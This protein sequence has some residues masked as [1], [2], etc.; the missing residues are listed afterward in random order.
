VLPQIFRWFPETALNNFPMLLT[1][2]SI[3]VVSFIVPLLNQGRSWG[4][5][6]L[7]ISTLFREEVE[8]GGLILSLSFRLGAIAVLTYAPGLVVLHTAKLLGFWALLPDPKI[9]MV[10]MA[11]VGW[12]VSW[13]F[14][15]GAPDKRGLLDRSAGAIQVEETILRQ[16]AVNT[17]LTPLVSALAFFVVVGLLIPRVLKYFA[18]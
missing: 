17:A 12:A 8:T 2:V 9:T 18:T 10:V 15:L 7:E 6:K 16:D 1:A 5:K 3:L 14:L 11:V 4:Q 13:L